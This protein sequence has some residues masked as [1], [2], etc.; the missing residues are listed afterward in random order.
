MGK[1]QVP[2]MDITCPNARQYHAHRPR[3]IDSPTCLCLL[4]AYGRVLLLFIQQDSLYY[5]TKK[6]IRG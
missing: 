6:I 1:K 4:T 2:G 5:D 3:P